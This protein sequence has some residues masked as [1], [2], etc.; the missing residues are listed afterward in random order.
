MKLF[1]GVPFSK[2]YFSCC[3]LKEPNLMLCFK[4]KSFLYEPVWKLWLSF[5]AHS[6]IVDSGN[7]T[8]IVHV[9]V[10]SNSLLQYHSSIHA[11]CQLET[12]LPSIFFWT[13]SQIPT[14]ISTLMEF[15]YVWFVKRKLWVLLMV[16]RVR[17]FNAYC[18][19]YLFS[20]AFSFSLLCLSCYE[21]WFGLYRNYLKAFSEI[22]STFYIKSIE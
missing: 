16:L 17:N 4:K 22:I 2:I 5:W 13:K 9:V 20:L 11:R 14:Q 3:P 1:I 15:D 12:L 19:L 7:Y 21:F 10:I 8:Y 18:V 6:Y